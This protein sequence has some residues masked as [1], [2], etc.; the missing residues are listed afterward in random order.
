MLKTIELTEHLDEWNTLMLSFIHYTIVFLAFY[1]FFTGLKAMRKLE[2]DDNILNKSLVCRGYLKEIKNKKTFVILMVTVPI[3]FFHAIKILSWQH[4]IDI[5]K[6][7]SSIDNYGWAI[8]HFIGAMS[9]ILY[10]KSI[11]NGRLT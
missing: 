4:S 7:W 10:H 9:F 2:K 6:Y 8:L 1:A 5:W 11:I 3:C